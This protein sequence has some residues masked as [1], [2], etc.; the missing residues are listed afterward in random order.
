METTLPTGEWRRFGTPVVVRARKAIQYSDSIDEMISILM[1]NNN[2]LMPN[3]W[4]M[5]DTKTGEI[6]SLELALRNHAITRIK[7]GFLWSC[8]NPKDDK[9]RWELNSP[10]GFGIIGRIVSKNFKPGPRDIKFE[11]LKNEYYGKINVDTAKKMMS[12]YPIRKPMFDCKITDSELVNDFGMWAHYG[13]VNGTDISLIERYSNFPGITNMPSCGWVD[14]YGVEEKIDFRPPNK[15]MKN[16]DNNDLIWSFE[17]YKDEFGNA[18]YSDPVIDEGNIYFTSWNGN[19]YCLSL[20]GEKNWDKKI[21]WNSVSTPT[22]YNGMVFVGSSDGISA[23]DKNT[24]EILW[25]KRIGPITSKP[26]VNKKMV[27][28]GSNDG[29]VYALDVDDGEI[30]WKYETGDDIYS[31]PSVEKEVLY[32]GSNDNYFY[33]LDAKTGRMLWK[34]ETDGPITSDSCSYKDLILFGSNDHNLYA[35][36]K[37]DGNLEWK[38]TTGWSVTS[39]PF[40]HNN[41]IFFGSRDNNLYALDPLEITLKWYFTADSAI[42]TTPRI[43]GGYVFF[44]SDDGKLYALDQ[45]NGDIIWVAKPDYTIDGIH[46]YVT[47]PIVSS[48]VA[49]EGNIYFGSTNGKIY[50]Y[51]SW[52]YEMTEEEKVTKK[53]E[54]PVFIAIVFVLIILSLYALFLLNKKK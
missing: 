37:K 46:S 53:D 32:I 10:F 13:Y 22:I 14:I 42:Q 39:A 20:N 33:A 54:F 18:I 31:S 3:D 6:A 5:G 43:Y 16:E 30:I 45:R 15:A 26:V 35:L 36:E 50:S 49:Y 24:G 7:N 12:T 21:G 34:F 41:T 51:D 47:K 29:Y 17:T 28:C 48:P 4:V 38:F 40:V 11:E 1:K 2:G 9:V 27:Y 23:L 25:D 52:T 19:L 44:G 8:N